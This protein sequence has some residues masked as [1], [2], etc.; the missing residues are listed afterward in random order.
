MILASREGNAKA[1]D[2]FSIV[3]AEDPENVDALTFAG[4][5]FLKL[6]RLAEAHAFLDRA[7]KIKAD[8]APA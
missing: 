8:F 3:L 5:A 7:I 1:A 2:Q 4:E 6:N